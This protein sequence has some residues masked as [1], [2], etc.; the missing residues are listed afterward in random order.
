M[1]QHNTGAGVPANP[2]G[3]PS[4]P[5]PAMPHVGSDGTYNNA[6]EA[7]LEDNLR[8]AWANRIAWP[9]EPA[10]GFHGM[11]PQN[12]ESVAFHFQKTAYAFSGLQSQWTKRYHAAHGGKGKAPTVHDML[13]KLGLNPADDKNGA[14]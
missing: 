9:V 5:Q 3:V 11:D 10:G 1:N 7:E 8:Q 12:N 4:L 2:P 13:I 14:R 6:T